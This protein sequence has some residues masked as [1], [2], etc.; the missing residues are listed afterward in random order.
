MGE[1]G[2]P[3]ANPNLP[4]NELTKIIKERFP[5]AIVQE[6]D[7]NFILFTLHSIG[8]S[9]FD[10][11]K[12]AIKE[13]DTMAEDGRNLRQMLGDVYEDLQSLGMSR[14]RA[15]SLYDILNICEN[16]LNGAVITNT[17]KWIEIPGLTR[18]INDLRKRIETRLNMIAHELEMQRRHGDREWSED[19]KAQVQKEIQKRKEANQLPPDG[20]TE[21]QRLQL[22]TRR[23]QR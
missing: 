11:M 18:E 22:F 21:Y 20:L 19:N 10:A 17:I 5:G 2:Q 23:G 16:T 14:K 12:N 8:S 3:L 7:G 1:P 6:S 13:Y 4:D 15:D 9:P